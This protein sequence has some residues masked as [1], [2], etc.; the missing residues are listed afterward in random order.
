[1]RI[2]LVHRYF[3]PDHP[4]CGQ[5]LWHLAKHLGLKGNKVEVLS[6]LPSKSQNSNKIKSK[7]NEVFKNI[8]IKRINLTIEGLDPTKKIINSLYLG[9]WTNY[10]AIKNNYDVIISTS[11]PPI[12]G[13]FFAALASTLTRTRFIY[14]CMD[15]HP[16]VGKISGDFSNYFFYLILKKIDSWSCSKANPIIVH[17][18]DMKK[19]LL[20]R[21]INNKFKIKVINNFSIPTK[22]KNKSSLGKIFKL[23]KKKLNIIFAGNLGR[24]QELEKIIEAMI[25]LKNR[26]D[27]ELIIIG[28]G[29]VKKD[30][31]LKLKNN[32]ANVKIFDYQPSAIAKNL[33]KNADIGLVSLSSSIYKYGYPGKIMTYLEQSKPII[34]VLEKKSSI[35]KLMEKENYGFCIPTLNPKKIAKMFIKIAE[36]RTWRKKMQKNA[37]I[38]YEKHFS[39]KKILRK[40]TKVLM[41]K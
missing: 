27:I 32:K 5:I 24:F 4:N 19:S 35:V 16:E 30:L 28:E 6:S 39:M 11:I 7:K 1:M 17:S 2:L 41:N 15:L 37:K 29:S 21:S 14:F 25:I 9:F 33:I 36:D 18:T 3:W 23:K 12:A 38:A 31:I 34:M 40:W 8:K 13:G 20:S 22:K 26:S 10:L